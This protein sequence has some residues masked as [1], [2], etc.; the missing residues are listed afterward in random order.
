MAE[1]F[2]NVLAVIEYLEA[3]GWKIGQSAAYNH[4]RQNK[5]VKNAKGVFTKAAVDRYA[6]SWLKLKGGPEDLRQ[7]S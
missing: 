2:P 5:L 3:R 1:S 7:A 4:V 6:S